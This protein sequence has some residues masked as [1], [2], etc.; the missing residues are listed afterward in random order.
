M[1]ITVGVDPA[2]APAAIK[3]F[4]R[5]MNDLWNAMDGLHQVGDRLGD[6]NVWDSQVAQEYRNK[7]AAL[8]P[9]LT[10]AKSSSGD[11]NNHVNDYEN[12]ITDLVT[13]S[14]KRTK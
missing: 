10:K 3:D 14:S 7:W 9:I 1:G 4:R 13:D 11:M 8:S 2:V 12:N 6:H 5:Y